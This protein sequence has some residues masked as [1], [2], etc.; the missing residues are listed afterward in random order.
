MKR[1]WWQSR[2]GRAG[3]SR[4]WAVFSF[5]GGTWKLVLYE[6]AFIV[7]PHVAV[8]TDIKETRPVFCSTDSLLLGVHPHAASSPATFGS[9]TP[10]LCHAAASLAVSLRVL[11]GDVK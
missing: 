8:G 1:W 7:P 6:G 10:A 9:A 5:S 11:G 2:L 3:L 4:G